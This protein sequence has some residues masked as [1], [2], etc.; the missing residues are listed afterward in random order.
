M[1]PINSGLK[2]GDASSP[3]LLN[4]SLEYAIRRI[5]EG[6]KLNGT[7]QRLFYVDSVKMLGRSML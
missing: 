7:H 4:L 2:Q 3:L 6:L 5:L 1:F